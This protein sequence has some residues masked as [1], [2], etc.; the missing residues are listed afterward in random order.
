METKARKKIQ[1]N[2]EDVSVKIPQPAL[3][4]EIAEAKT[5]LSVQV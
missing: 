2:V 1:M 3:F 4:P 5:P